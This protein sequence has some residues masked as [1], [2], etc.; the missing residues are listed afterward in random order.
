M[1]EKKLN[2]LLGMENFQS[3]EKLNKKAKATKRTSVAKDVLQENAYVTGKKDA[4]TKKK[5]EVPSGKGTTVKP[6]GKEVLGD[7]FKNTEKHASK[8]LNNLMSMSDFTKNV[9]AT[10]D[11]A[12]KR[13]STAKDVLQEKKAENEKEKESDEKKKV[14]EEEKKVTEEEKEEEPKKGLTAKQKKLPKGLQDAIL[15]RQKK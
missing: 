14:T 7:S 10:K 5:V 2:N 9:P 8:G 1:K 11:K 15:K 13:T 12:T 4:L 6:T 3:V